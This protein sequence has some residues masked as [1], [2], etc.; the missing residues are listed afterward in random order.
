MQH[1]QISFI[2]FENNWEL[3]ALERVLKSTS[4]NSGTVYCGR[5]SC[6]LWR[7]ASSIPVL[8]SFSNCLGSITKVLK[9]HLPGRVRISL[10]QGL[11]SLLSRF[12]ESLFLAL[13]IQ[14]ISTCTFESSNTPNKLGCVY[15]LVR[16]YE[17]RPMLASCYVLK[18][19]VN[20]LGVTQCCFSSNL[21]PTLCSQVVSRVCDWRKSSSPHGRQIVKSA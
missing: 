14:T 19:V 13:H 2:K 10:A 8:S 3:F 18:L 9:N 1:I 6:S 15:D 20:S 11:F 17:L 7:M 21:F 16:N 5:V 12:E 4:E